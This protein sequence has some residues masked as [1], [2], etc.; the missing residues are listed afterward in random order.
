MRPVRRTSTL[1]AAMLATALALPTAVYAVPPEPP[2][3]TAP[4]P[5]AS[6]STPSGASA[7]TAPK[8]KAKKAKK[9]QQTELDSAWEGYRAA[10]AM[11]YTD[12]DYAGGIASCVR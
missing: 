9:Q 5:R 11:I 1:A 2:Q 3:T 6:T 10:Y 8:K 7:T 4:A 12:H